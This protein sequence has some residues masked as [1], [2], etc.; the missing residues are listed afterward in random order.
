VGGKAQRAAFRAVAGDLKLAYAQFEELET[1]AKFGAR[2]DDATRKTIEHGRRIRSC[3][4]QAEFD[5]VSVPAQVAV[6]LALTADLFDPVPLER[7]SEA[8]SAVHLAVDGMDETIRAR[9]ESEDKLRDEDRKSVLDLCRTA[10]APFLPS[11]DPKPTAVS[12]PKP[13]AKPDPEPA[14]KK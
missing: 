1:F 3:L 13:D 4:K 11:K 12:D 2:L 6:L 10:I 14:K 7:M 9:L 5:P 8:E